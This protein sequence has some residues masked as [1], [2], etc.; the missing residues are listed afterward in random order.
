[1]K[2]FILITCLFIIF[3]SC[4]KAQIEPTQLSS[5]S[6]P[7]IDTS[8]RHPKNS[9]FKTLLEK[10]HQKGLPGISLLVNDANGTWVGSIGKADIE[11]NIPFQ[12]GQVSK[13][14]SIT[15]LFIGS[16]VFKLM[17]DSVNT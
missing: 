12:V 1:M 14:A 16:L 10:Y 2:N 4:K 7:W 5:L 6:V 3:F 13:I 15:K 17:E 9:A 8:D 11:R